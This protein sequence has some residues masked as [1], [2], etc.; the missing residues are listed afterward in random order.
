MPLG[1]AAVFLRLTQREH[2]AVV[3]QRNAGQQRVDLFD[4]C[5]V[6]A[7][8]GRA[9]G[10]EPG[11]EHFNFV[12]RNGLD[13]HIADADLIGV[14]GALALHGC[15]VHGHA[16][17]HADSHR[18]ADQLCRSK[19]FP[20]A[21]NRVVINDARRAQ[22]LHP[23]GIDRGGGGVGREG[24]GRMDMVVDVLRHHGREFGRLQNLLEICKAFFPCGRVEF[25]QN[26]DLD[27][28]AALSSA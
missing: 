24:I 9:V 20:R 17:F 16:A 5:A 1:H 27:H 13:G 7:A 28:R 8:S 4:H 23:R 12:V 10:R 22:A 19:E 18:H 6:P 2:V 3:V 14:V 21:G 25:V 15:A 26:V 11:V